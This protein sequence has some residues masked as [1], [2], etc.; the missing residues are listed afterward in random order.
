[1]NDPFNQIKINLEQIFVR[2]LLFPFHHKCILGIQAGACLGAIYKW[3]H[4]K[5]KFVTTCIYTLHHGLTLGL[6]PQPYHVTSFMN[7]P[8]EELSNEMR[9]LQKI[10]ALS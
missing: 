5:L 10:W 1:M 8:S 9:M 3:R 4:A 2:N 7:G 6:P